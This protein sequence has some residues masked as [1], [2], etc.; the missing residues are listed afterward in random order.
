MF[1][2]LRDNDSPFLDEEQKPPQPRQRRSPKSEVGFLGMTAAQRFVLSL[3]IFFMVCAC[4]AFVL[5]LSG[6]VSLPF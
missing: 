4:G 2:D 6:K 1:D 5:I 3:L